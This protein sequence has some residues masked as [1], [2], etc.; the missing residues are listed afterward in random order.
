MEQLLD[1]VVDSLGIATFDFSVLQAL[2]GASKSTS[3][4]AGLDATLCPE[5]M[6]YGEFDCAL[7][8]TLRSRHGE[9]RA[10]STPH[11]GQTYSVRRAG[12]AAK[13]S[14]ESSVIEVNANDLSVDGG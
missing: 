10:F 2:S 4:S 6:T 5:T 12:K 14:A 7:T 9:R 11:S 3:T 13:S 8:L 1:L